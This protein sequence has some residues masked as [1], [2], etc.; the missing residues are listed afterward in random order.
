[1]HYRYSIN[2]LS[3]FFFDSV[4][5][6]LKTMCVLWKLSTANDNIFLLCTFL[7]FEFDSLYI[8]KQGEWLGHFSIH[9]IE[10]NDKK[11]LFDM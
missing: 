5:V 4:K 9:L 7:K 2:L 3:H 1:M 6:K 11:M 10:E 8:I